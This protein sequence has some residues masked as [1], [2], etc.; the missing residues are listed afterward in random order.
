MIKNEY[1][2]TDTINRNIDLNL[3]NAP[4]S[5]KIDYVDKEIRKYD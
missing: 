4:A 1:E 5:L 3:T 2:L